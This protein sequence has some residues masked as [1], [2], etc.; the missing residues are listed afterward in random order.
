MLFDVELT[1]FKQQ[2]LTYA[3]LTEFLH[4]IYLMPLEKLLRSLDLSLHF[5]GVFTIVYPLYCIV[6]SLAPHRS[7]SVLPVANFLFSL[8]PSL[9]LHSLLVHRSYFYQNKWKKSSGRGRKESYSRSV[10]RL[11]VSRLPSSGFS[12]Y[13]LFCLLI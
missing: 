3:L 8:F 10:F 5:W 7:F 2:H 13:E 6:S 9:A 12:H 1:A 11:P 4:V